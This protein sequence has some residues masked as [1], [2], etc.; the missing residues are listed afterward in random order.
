MVAFFLY[1]QPVSFYSQN[2]QF[3]E[4]HYSLFDS[5]VGLGNNAIY[6]GIEYEKKYRT[7]DESNEFYLTS[8]FIKGNIIYDAQPYYNIDL[9]YDVLDDDL[10]VKLPDPYKGNSII[11][12]LKDKVKSFYILEKQ[13]VRLENNQKN[14]LDDLSSGFYQLLYE[15]NTL[16]IY[17]KHIKNRTEKTDR[18]YIYYTFKDINDYYLSYNNNFKKVKFKRDFVKIFPKQ[19]NNINIFFKNNKAMYNSNYDLFLEKLAKHM[20]SLIAIKKTAN[21]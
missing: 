4:N 2:L 18:E 9:K 17:K 8:Q 21:E 20:D 14:T 5:I 12:L 10:I 1:M 7:L 6:N 13:F 19:K 15:S 11:R 3:D 16:G